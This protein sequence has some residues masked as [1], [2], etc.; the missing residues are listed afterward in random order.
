MKETFFLT[1]NKNN[2]FKPSIYHAKKM[3]YILE[4]TLL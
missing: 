2:N 1:I 4:S 3:K